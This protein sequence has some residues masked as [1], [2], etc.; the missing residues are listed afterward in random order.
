MISIITS[1]YKSE[2]HL[3][4]FIKRVKRMD[5][6]LNKKDIV[7]EFII[8]PNNPSDIEKEI[9]KQSI[10]NVRIIPRDLESLYATWNIGVKS[11]KYDIVC[12]WN[13]DD[14][15][16]GK[17]ILAGLKDIRD[18]ADIVYFSFIY[19][20]YLR[21]GNIKIL[22]K[23]KFFISPIFDREVFSKEMRCDPFSMINKRSFSKIGFFNE[24]FFVAGDYDWCVRATL[25]GLTF[26][27]NIT[28]AGIF[29]SDG[30]TLS[31]SKSTRHAM[32]NERI[33][34]MNRT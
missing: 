12:F 9:L 29:T 8:L 22:A 15:R 27:R 26:K 7:H 17:G 1:L 28:I 2:Q 33:H 6:Y 23:I 3:P 30:K 10:G 14:V 34:N 13:V 5:K 24:T 19:F 25:Y 20:R 21:I 18:G 11:A 32:E 16:F 31:G 4:S